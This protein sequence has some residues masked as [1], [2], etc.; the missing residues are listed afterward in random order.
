M[1]TTGSDFVANLKILTP[2]L[3]PQAKCTII[4]VLDDPQVD[5]M[6]H[7]C[8]V[9]L[10]GKIVFDDFLADL[11]VFGPD[12]VLLDEHFKPG[13]E[14]LGLVAV[15]GMMYPTFERCAT[16]TTLILPRSPPLVTATLTICVVL[17]CRVP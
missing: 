13:E 17:S 6:T 5:N 12:F 4:D 1:Q 10:T 7:L 3:P 15:A 11:L 14:N 16:H 2:T 9:S 8:E